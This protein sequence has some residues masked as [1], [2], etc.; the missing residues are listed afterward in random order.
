MNTMQHAI[1]A[2]VDGSRVQEASE[3]LVALGRAQ[4]AP[5]IR[6]AGIRRLRRTVG[7]AGDALSATIER[8][9]ARRS[10]R[11]ALAALERLDDRVLRDIGLRRDDLDAVRKGSTTLAALDATRRQRSAPD[12]ATVT[13]LRREACAPRAL[14]DAA[15]PFARC[16]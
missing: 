5:A 6:K 14:L 1:N 9:L 8:Y 12:P 16:A 4:S 2:L 15:Q 3:H 7:T 10:E 13:T 11:R